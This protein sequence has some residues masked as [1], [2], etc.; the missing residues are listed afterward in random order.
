MSKHSYPQGYRPWY[1][2]PSLHVRIE[3]LIEKLADAQWDGD[4]ERVEELTTQLTILIGKEKMGDEYDP[5]F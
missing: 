1:E 2:I 3:R 4:D 5:A